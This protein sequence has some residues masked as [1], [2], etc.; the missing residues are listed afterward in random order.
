MKLIETIFTP[1]MISESNDNDS[2]KPL[3][4]RGIFQQAEVINKNNRIYPRDLLEREVNKLQERIK[5]RAFFAGMDHPSSGVASIKET[6]A[7]ITDLFMDGNDLKGEAEIVDTSVGKDLKA[8]L[9]AGAQIGI[10]SRGTGEIEYNFL[11]GKKVGIVKDF[12]LE[13]FDFVVNPSLSRASVHALIEATMK[14]KEE[15]MEKDKKIDQVTNENKLLKDKI[16]ELE[17]KLKKAIVEAEL[18]KIVKEEPFGRI[19]AERLADCKDIEELKEKIKKEKEFINKV[20]QE[21][22]L[23]SGLGK[24]RISNNLS[25]KDDD[26]LKREVEIAR[27]LID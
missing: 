6:A 19:L 24:Q 11:D 26:R 3:K 10:S 8:L 9:L 14:N 12:T 18:Q 23:P 7:I 25:I 1:L 21:A 15:L 27:R 22:S 20:I 5:S 4:V 17:E 2:K 16:K 13:G